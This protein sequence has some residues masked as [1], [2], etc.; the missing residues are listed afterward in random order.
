MNDI[1]RYLVEKN[2]ADLLRE[3]TSDSFD[4]LD[5]IIESRDLDNLHKEEDSDA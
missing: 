3:V 2:K 1:E 4:F 5:L